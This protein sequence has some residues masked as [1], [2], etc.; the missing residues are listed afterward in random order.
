ME[1]VSGSSSGYP[2]RLV[3][4]GMM[5]CLSTETAAGLMNKELLLLSSAETGG[6]NLILYKGFL[7]LSSDP[8]DGSLPLCTLHP[9]SQTVSLLP[10]QPCVFRKKRCL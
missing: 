3:F 2:E 6:R 10:T 9:G 7:C 8:F 5:P 4:I 1:I